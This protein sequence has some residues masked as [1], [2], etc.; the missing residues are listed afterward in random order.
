MGGPIIFDVI[1][2][3]RRLLVSEAKRWVGFTEMGG[4]NKGQIVEA[5]QKAV[6]GKAV[7]EAWCLSWAMFCC[8][9]V[10]AAVSDIL[11]KETGLHALENTEHC[12]T[13]WYKSPVTNQ[14]TEPHPGDIA[15]WRHG[16]SSSGHCGIVVQVEN[17][18]GYMWTVEGNTSSTDSSVQREGDGV[19]LKRRNIR[20]TGSMKVIGFLQPWV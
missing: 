8:K 11:E 19:Y 3:K 1:T 12:L 2:M 6:D 17:G 7:G 14:F 18:T 10:D 16:T 5:F 13:C 15:I 4:D 20:A 9:N